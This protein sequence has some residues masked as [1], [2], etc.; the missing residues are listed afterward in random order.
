MKQIE[1]EN[2]TKVTKYEAIDGTV[3]SF[4][5]DCIRYEESAKCVL[6]SKYKKLVVKEVVEDTLYKTGSDENN[7]DIV[8]LKEE[9]DID[10]VMQLFYYYNNSQYSLKR[11]E[12]VREIC[13]KAFKEDDLL[14]IYRG[15]SSEDNFWVRSTV[16]DLVSHIQNTCYEVDKA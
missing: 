2:V 4:K 1:I 3:F 7:L 16:N 12:E 9:K 13:V 11:G 15:Y 8:S 10:V 6:L 14:I 5:E